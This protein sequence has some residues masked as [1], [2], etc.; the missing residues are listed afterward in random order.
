MRS[1]FPAI[2]IASLAFVPGAAA[3]QSDAVSPQVAVVE[4]FVMQTPSTDGFVHIRLSPD[5]GDDLPALK[6]QLEQMPGVRVGNPADYELTNV[7]DFPKTLLAVDQHQAEADWVQGFMGQELLEEHPYDFEDHPRT[8]VLG[9]LVVGDYMR[10]R[11]AELVARTAA[12]KTLIALGQR[13]AKDE[14]ETCVKSTDPYAPD[15]RVSVQCHPGPYR[16]PETDLASSPDD[17]AYDG[18]KILVQNRSDRPRYVIV[19]LIDPAFGTH[20]LD[21]AAQAKFA[22]LAPGASAE[23]LSLSTDENA[24]AGRYRLVTIWSDQPFDPDA[25]PPHIRRSRVFDFIR[26]ISERG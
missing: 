23:A 26:R 6:A 9:N 3:A 10:E 17:I 20:R 11:C 5:L 21:F 7:R 14:I 8:I 2:S 16:E 15:A 1:W 18:S 22:Q 12:A 19:F 4:Q 13:G 24:L 25:T